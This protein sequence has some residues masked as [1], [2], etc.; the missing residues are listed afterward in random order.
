MPQV[1]INDPRFHSYMKTID[2]ELIADTINE[3]YLSA[4]DKMLSMKPRTRP[5]RYGLTTKPGV[6]WVGLKFKK[7]NLRR[8]V[9]SKD[10]S[11]PRTASCRGIIQG[12]RHRDVLESELGKESP[13]LS[14]VGRML[15][16][17]GACQL[18]EQISADVKSAFM[19][20]DSIDKGARIFFQPSSN[21]R[22]RF[23]T[24]MG[25]RDHQVLKATKPAFGDVRAPRQWYQTAVACSFIGQQCSSNM[26]LF[27]SV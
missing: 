19:Q 17:Q 24:M 18:H 11:P 20:S 5:C 15:I 26:A 6:S 14:R 4:K 16:L 22:K 23:A 25:F 3:K 7:V 12:F 13:T 1:E 8:R 21:M 9:C 10:G 2:E 27:D